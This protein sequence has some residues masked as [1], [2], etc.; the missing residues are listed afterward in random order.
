MLAYVIDQNVDI[1]VQLATGTGRAR[2]ALIVSLEPLRF[3]RSYAGLH[4]LDDV[5]DRE[6]L[7]FPAAEPILQR[8]G[9]SD[10]MRAVYNAIQR[11]VAPPGP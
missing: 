2:V 6:A 3:F 7:R 1:A 4:W 5:R 8:A 10:E 9:N 11:W